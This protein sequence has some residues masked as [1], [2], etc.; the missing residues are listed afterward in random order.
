MSISGK[1]SFWMRCWDGSASQRWVGWVGGEGILLVVLPF[2]VMNVRSPSALSTAAGKGLLAK[3]WHLWKPNGSEG[4]G[5][6]VQVNVA[7]W[8]Q[9]GRRKR[10]SFP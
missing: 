2:G 3:S 9:T 7:L 5:C 8:R 4:V 10:G 1:H 6:A